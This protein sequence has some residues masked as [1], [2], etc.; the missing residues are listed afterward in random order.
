MPSTVVSPSVPGGTNEPEPRVVAP[1]DSSWAGW[2][3]SSFTNKIGTANGEIEPTLNPS[4][5][6]DPETARSASLPRPSKPDSSHELHKQVPRHVAQPLNRSMSD[7]PAPVVQK[8]EVEEGDEVF[9]AWGAMD[10]DEPDVDPFTA[11]VTSPKP[12]SPAPQPAQAPYEDGEP[13]F[14]AWLANKSQTK[15]KKTLPKGLNKAASTNSVATRSTVAKPQTV[16]PA[17][18]IDMKP[19]HEEVDDDWGDAWD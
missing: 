8:D 1:S 3:I 6:T 13:D 14:A 19:K 5:S 17:K 16:A 4:K 12:L 15:A 10:D 7:R 11:A 18:K 9:D 2:A